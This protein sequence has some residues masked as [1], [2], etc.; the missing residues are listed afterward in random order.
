MR[1]TRK[2]FA[3]LCAV[4]AAI[5]PFIFIFAGG[6]EGTK[7]S[8]T[9][10][11]TPAEAVV[12]VDLN[13][14]WTYYEEETDPVLSG[15]RTAW[16]ESDFDVSAWKVTPEGKK[17]IFGAKKGALKDVD[18]HEPEVLLKQYKESNGKN[19]EAFFFRTTFNLDNVPAD[20]I[21][22]GELLHDDAALVYLNGELIAE[23]DNYQE[24]DESKKFDANMQ[25]GGNGSLRSNIFEIKT[26][27]LKQGENI[28]AVELHQCSASSSDIFFQMTSLELRPLDTKQKTIALNVGKDETCRNISWYSSYEDPGTVQYGIKDD[29]EFPE[30]YVE[31]EASIEPTNNV[32]LFSNK[33]EMENLLPNTTYAYRVVNHDVV[34]PV[35]TFTT[36]GEGD[37]GFFAAGDPQIGGGERASDS[38]K[39]DATL[40]KA[41]Q[42]F[43]EAAFLLSAGDQVNSAA[44]EEEYTGYLERD[45]L[46]SLPLAN[47]IGNHDSGSPAYTQHF[48]NPNVTQYGES[49]AGTNYWYTYNNVLFLH[50]NSNS[51][52]FAEHRAFMEEAIAACPDVD[53]KVVTFHHSIYSAANHATSDGILKRRENYVPIFEDL[54][55]DV[56]LMGHDHIY[57]RSYMM[58]GFEPVKVEADTAEVTNPE[59]ILY[60]TL[61][62]SSGS[63]YYSMSGEFDYAAVQSQE[64]IPSI[65]YV[66]VTDH[67]FDITVYRLDAE[68]SVM[69][70]FTI[71]KETDLAEQDI[72]LS[73]T[74]YTYNGKAKKPKVSIAG[75]EEGK[76][77]TVKYSDNV[78]AGKAKVTITGKGKYVGQVEKSFT[79]KKAKL[80]YAKLKTT[81]FTYNGNTKR[82]AVT[83]KSGDTVLMQAKNQDNASVNLTY[84]KGRKNPGT[85]K[86]TIAGKGDYTGTLTRTFKI[87]LKETTL[88]KPVAGKKAF[89]AKWTKLEKKQVT[90][91][92]IRYSTSSKMTKATTKYAKV[93]SYKTTSKKIQKLKAKKK[94]YVQIRTYKVIGT[95]TY[96]SNWSK[97]KTVTTK[98]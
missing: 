87:R 58:E 85:Y 23:Y 56:V 61:N 76:D 53:W 94:Y 10:A 42:K 64:R 91:Y 71:K 92:Q 51:G 28:L 80:T 66:S 69:D 33:A 54:D 46:K 24:A 68:M 55:I 26:K 73:K 9:E 79:I 11:S 20:M 29:Q 3:A 88:K 38:L 95:K 34:S 22:R 67:S 83:V 35:Y 7:A 8:A 45:A 17:S 49:K 98:R 27:Y 77:Y 32:F 84:A 60:M 19:T 6:G 12:L 41:T 50:M 97:T 2:K 37:F 96:Y 81:A 1:N 39:W 74:S 13:T 57:V 18:D 40:T 86:V 43:P 30:E 48:N 52:S 65:A 62:S 44:N 36:T 16:V 25:Y 78:H 4:L 90:G 59:G 89:T 93:K 15:D 72:K 70:Q 75:L 63:K 82:P 14:P 31:A 47:N 5:S 21:L